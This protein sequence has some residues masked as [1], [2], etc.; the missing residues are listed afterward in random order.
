M[1]VVAFTFLAYAHLG[2]TV[3]TKTLVTLLLAFAI[4]LIQVFWK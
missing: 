2:E 3:T 4:V 1:G